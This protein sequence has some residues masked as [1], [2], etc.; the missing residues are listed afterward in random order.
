M[1]MQNHQNRIC[2]SCNPDPIVCHAQRREGAPWRC[3]A[4]GEAAPPFLQSGAY[5]FLCPFPYVA[6]RRTTEPSGAKAE[7]RG[8]EPRDRAASLS[9]SLQSGLRPPSPSVVRVVQDRH[10]S[11]HWLMSKSERGGA[12]RRRKD[13]PWMARLG[14]ERWAS[15]EPGRGGLRDAPPHW[16]PPHFQRRPM[17]GP[18]AVGAR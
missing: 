5:R 11:R 1:K 9:H 3:V 14:V 7:P 16:A 13:G 17:R 18:W 12:G 4:V 6:S 10:G 2:G 8:I 15:G